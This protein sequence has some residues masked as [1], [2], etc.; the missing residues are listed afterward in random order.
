VVSALR[1]FDQAIALLA[2]ID[3]AFASFCANANANASCILGP[4]VW[5]TSNILPDRQF[6]GVLLK[7][8]FGYTQRLYLVQAIGYL[9]FL[10]VVGGL[11]LQSITGWNIGKVLA[12]RQDVS[13]PVSPQGKK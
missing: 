2:Q 7:A 13:H 4:L 1:H 8:F 11:Y 3:P 10:T 12:A 6:P 9:L 5:D